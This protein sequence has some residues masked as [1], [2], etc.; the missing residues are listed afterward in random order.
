[1]TET[2]ILE[3][4]KFCAEC[5]SRSERYNGSIAMETRELYDYLLGKWDTKEP[6]SATPREET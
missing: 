1:M 6:E 5:A 3:L 4:R 2:E